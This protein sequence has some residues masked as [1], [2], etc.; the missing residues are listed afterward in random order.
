MDIV[1]TFPGGKR[2]D[3]LIDGLTLPTDQPVAAGGAGSAVAPFDLF[4]ASLGTCAGY[5]VLAYCQAR[6]LDTT[7]LM[8]VQH[9]TSDP[10]THLPARIDIDVRLP[11]GFPESH[12]AGVK[13]AADY[14]KVKKVLANPPVVAVRLLADERAASLPASL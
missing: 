5:Y 1:V 12:R 3:A 14:C 4:L 13:R 11:A 2:V 9:V 8:V 10:A 7:G 6:G